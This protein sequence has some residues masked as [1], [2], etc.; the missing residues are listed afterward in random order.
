MR[1]IG[2]GYLLCDEISR[3]AEGIVYKAIAPPGDR[4]AI[5]E[6][7]IDDGRR[8]HGALIKVLA[9]NGYRLSHVVRCLGGFPDGYSYYVVEEALSMPLEEAFPPCTM[10][11]F[12]LQHVAADT[13]GAAAETAKA[14]LV[15]CDLKPANFVLSNS[16]WRI[17]LV[18]FGCAVVIGET[19]R[20]Y[21]EDC[22]SP[23]VRAGRP[24]VT[25]DVYSWSRTMEYLLTGMVDIGPEYAVTDLTPW[26]PPDFAKLIQRCTSEDWASRPHPIS[27]PSL[28]RR[29]LA[30][31][32]TCRNCRATRFS[33]TGVCPCC[34]YGHDKQRPGFL[35]TWPLTI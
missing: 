16:W 19:T 8:E 18:D 29:S 9:A 28:V 5:K 10:T 1:S 25:S 21:A 17:V 11:A 26:V 15:H 23:E 22:S 34:S 35:P 27:L 32:E 3:G 7:Q 4:V 20:G 6:C 12:V 24:S 31:T 33:N 2:P 30:A 13:A 14:G